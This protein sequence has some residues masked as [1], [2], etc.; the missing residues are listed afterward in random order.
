MYQTSW[1]L[2]WVGCRTVGVADG[3]QN[4]KGHCKQQ[5]CRRRTRC[6]RLWDRN[7]SALPGYRRRRWCRPP[8][9][10]VGL[11]GSSCRS[12]RLGFGSPACRSRSLGR[13]NRRRSTA[14]GNCRERRRRRCSA[15]HSRCH[16][17]RNQSRP[18]RS[19]LGLVGGLRMQGRR[20]RRGRQ[21]EGCDAL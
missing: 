13:R 6:Q 10:R 21:R 14:F 18:R 15:C 19:G 7:R 8:R 3:C 11:R 4:R 12:C 2:W 17:H 20:R 5:S 9:R 16:R 1:R